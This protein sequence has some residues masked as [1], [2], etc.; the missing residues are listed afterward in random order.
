MRCVESLFR[1]QF[2]VLA[3]IRYP[4]EADGKD[5]CDRIEG[6]STL[7]PSFETGFPEVCDDD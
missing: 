1:S 3:V 7:P 4:D 6:S 5:L 2:R